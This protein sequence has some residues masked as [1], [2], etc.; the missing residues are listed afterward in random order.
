MLT[1]KGIIAR[2]ILCGCCYFLS[3]T[4][5]LTGW[6]AG[7][8]GVLGTI[9]LA[10]AFLQYSPLAEL[11]DSLDL[12]FEPGKVWADNIWIDKLSHMFR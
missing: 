9:A 11:M 7:I 1:K 2:Y 8:S 10:S 3:G 4:Q 5:I 12:R 6:P